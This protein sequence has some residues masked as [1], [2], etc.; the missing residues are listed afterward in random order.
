M[1]STI[2]N[3]I[4][5]Y[6]WFFYISL[7]QLIA[8]FAVPALIVPS[9]YVLHILIIASLTMGLIVALFFLMVNIAGFFIDK[10]RRPLYISFM[11]F[12]SLWLIWAA[13]SWLYI[14]HMDYILR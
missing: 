1:K 9:R 3:K 5:I 7:A 14:E 11:S 2:D 8:F 13:I 4:V 12:C 6:R 10:T